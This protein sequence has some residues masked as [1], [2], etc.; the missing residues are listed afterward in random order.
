MGLDALTSHSRMYMTSPSTHTCHSS[1]GHRWR[2]ALSAIQLCSA[3][4]L[5]SKWL[6]C[7]MCGWIWI[8]IYANVVQCSN[9][10]LSNDSPYRHHH[11]HHHYDHRHGTLSLSLYNCSE[12]GC[13]G[14]EREGQ[15]I[16]ARLHC[17]VTRISF[18]WKQRCTCTIP[19]RTR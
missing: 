9:I 1:T 19:V 6:W 16:V 5:I 14:G 12:R 7:T 2:W 13:E 11:H 17:L 10:G 15:I 8:W 4:V 3:C 18:C